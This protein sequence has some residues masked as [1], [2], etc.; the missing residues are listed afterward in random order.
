M[1]LY[2]YAADRMFPGDHTVT[3]R[4]S[5]T[6]LCDNNHCAAL[7]LDH[8]Y[9]KT[10]LRQNYIAYAEGTHGYETVPGEDINTPIDDLI[11][12]MSS[13]FTKEDIYIALQALQEKEYITCEIITRRQLTPGAKTVEWLHYLTHIR[14]IDNDVTMLRSKL[15]PVEPAQPAKPVKPTVPETPIP[16]NIP[17]EQQYRTEFARIKY[18]NRRA[19]SIGLAATLTLE[20]WLKTLEHFDWKCSYCQELYTVIE[21][22]VPLT[23]GEEGTTAANCIP[24]CHKCNGLKGSDHP[25][26]I[27]DNARAKIGQAMKE[28]QEYLETRRVEA[29]L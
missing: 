16:Y 26:T 29:A 28:V 4:H 1:S 14:T 25:I 20:Q 7:L 17:L 2:T 15:A 18:H 12:V 13:L 5:F 27:S 10:Q 8:F 23:I 24:A 3:L 22:F 11:E 9:E 21:H 6:L 19:S